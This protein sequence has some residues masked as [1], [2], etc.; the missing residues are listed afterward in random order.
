MP[1]FVI[2]LHE[3]GFA[4]THP[5]HFDFMLEPQDDNALSTWRWDQLPNGTVGFK[6]LQL[7]P[8][9]LEYLDYEGEISGGRGHVSQQVTGIYRDA[10]SCRDSDWEIHL[11]AEGL[12][13]MLRGLHVKG[14]QWLF[15]FRQA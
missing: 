5:R 2:L 3:P 9:R 4:S 6:G 7:T 11:E 14:A 1:R 13:G 8:H 12:T 10:I 15:D